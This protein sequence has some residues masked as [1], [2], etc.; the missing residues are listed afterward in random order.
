MP[1]VRF[2]AIIMPLY[3][4]AMLGPLLLRWKHL[5]SD[6]KRL[7]LGLG[8]LP[9]AFAAIFGIAMLAHR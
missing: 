7:R 1:L 8:L 4:I 5:T 6:E 2:L 3:A 9:L